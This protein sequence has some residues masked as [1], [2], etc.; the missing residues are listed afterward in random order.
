VEKNK[1]ILK[2]VTWGSHANKAFDNYCEEEEIEVVEV[3]SRTR[4]ILFVLP[5]I[6]IA[7]ILLKNKTFSDV[8]FSDPQYAYLS[9]RLWMKPMTKAIVQTE[10]GKTFGLI[11][12]LEKD[13]EMILQ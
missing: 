3:I 1:K 13:V 10:E 2:I 5:L 11:Q 4:I 8:Y 9:L 12:L 6:L 7:K